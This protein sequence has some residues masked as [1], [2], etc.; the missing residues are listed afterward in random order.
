MLTAVG[1]RVS[2]RHWTPYA[3]GPLEVST[4]VEQVSG[5]VGSLVGGPHSSVMF[6]ADGRSE[7]RAEKEASSEARAADST[8]AAVPV[9]GAFPVLM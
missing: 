7:A 5:T 1:E 6:S 3:A 2:L 8:E 9:M 4:G